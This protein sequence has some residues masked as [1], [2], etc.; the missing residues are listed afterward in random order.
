MFAII[1]TGSK[2]HKVEKGNK[3]EIEKL[4]GKV[5]ETVTFHKVLLMENNGNLEIGTPVILGATVT[6]KILEHGL[7]EKV[8]VFKMK[9]KKRY[10]RN[11]GFRQPFTFVEILEIKKS[12]TT[13][14]VEKPAKEV[15]EEKKEK[16]AKTVVTKKKITAPKTV[17]KT[18]IK[19]A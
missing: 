1:E 6:A 9:A 10:K 19:K 8:T 4:D 16:P 11:R 12:A 7:G 18:A 3:L 13:K 14:L 17:K 5:G 2:Q 15:K